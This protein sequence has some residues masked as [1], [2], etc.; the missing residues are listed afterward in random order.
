M[1]KLKLKAAS[2]EAVTVIVVMRL[3]MKLIGIQMA[4]VTAVE[5]VYTVK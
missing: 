3:L 2:D 4:E 5:K 1:K